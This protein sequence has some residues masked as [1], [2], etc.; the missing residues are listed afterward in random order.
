MFFLFPC[1][2]CR[3][4]YNRRAN[5]YAPVTYF[6]PPTASCQPFSDNTSRIQKERKKSFQRKKHC[7]HPPTTAV[8]LVSL[9]YDTTDCSVLRTPAILTTFGIRSFWPRNW[10]KWLLP[11]VVAV[12][13]ART[14]T[15][16]FHFWLL[17]PCVIT[18][19]DIWLCSPSRRGPWWRPERRSSYR[20]PSG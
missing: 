10:P 13:K 14:G 5:M 12:S 4:K 15:Q 6:I 7:S 2:L 9:Q 16:A 18:C 20:Y 17:I 11:H 8:S 1:I 19:S 3:L